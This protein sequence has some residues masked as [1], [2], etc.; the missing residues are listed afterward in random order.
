ML[1]NLH[2]VTS[3]SNDPKMKLIGIPIKNKIDQIKKDYSSP[4]WYPSNNF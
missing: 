1:Y 3:S 4:Y 2:F